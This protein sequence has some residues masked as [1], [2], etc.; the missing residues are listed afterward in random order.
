MMHNLI[1]DSRYPLLQFKMTLDPPKDL[2][3]NMAYT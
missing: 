2:T 1:Q 3:I